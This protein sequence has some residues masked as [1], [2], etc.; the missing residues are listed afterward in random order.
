ML[1]L[2]VRY[3]CH[4]IPLYLH[5]FLDLFESNRFSFLFVCFI[6]VVSVK[7]IDVR[8]FLSS[9]PLVLLPFAR[10][11]ETHYFHTDLFARILYWQQFFFF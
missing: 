10:V 4:F 9:L 6:A 2:I 3:F 8:S 1:A 5:V 7:R 11:N